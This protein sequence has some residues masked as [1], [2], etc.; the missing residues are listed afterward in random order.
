MRVE[1]KRL[2]MRI[3]SGEAVEDAYR[4]LKHL[5]HETLD[6]ETSADDTDLLC[7]TFAGLDSLVAHEVR[8]PSEAALTLAGP[9]RRSSTSQHTSGSSDWSRTS[10]SAGNQ[11]DFGRPCPSYLGQRAARYQCSSR[12]IGDERLACSLGPH[13]SGSTI[14]RSAID[15]N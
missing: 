4:A 8:L 3:R 2:A 14:S 11:Y 5:V 9:C 10:K 7:E 15:Y 12:S 6:R 1:F 13:I